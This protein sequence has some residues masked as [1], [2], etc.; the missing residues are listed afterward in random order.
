MNPEERISRVA[1]LCCH[2][3]RNLAYYRAGWRGQRI[4]V[5]RQFWINANGGFLNTAVLEWCKLFAERDG[6]HHWRSIVNDH[7]AFADGLYAYLR[8]SKKEFKN[9]AKSVLRYRNKFVAHL[10]EECVMHIPH[11]RLARKCAAFLYDYLLNDPTSKLC[12]PDAN[13]SAASYYAI[14]YRHAYQEYFR[15]I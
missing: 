5:Q 3:L 7:S 11:M 15:G 14:M 1:I 6:Q 13:Y 2:C 8:I 4:R 10:D 12:L 9:Y